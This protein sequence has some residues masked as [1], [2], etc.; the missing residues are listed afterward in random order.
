MYDVEKPNL[1]F[2]LAN[3]GRISIIMHNFHFKT[4]TLYLFATAKSR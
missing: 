3:F 1:K 2:Y 4:E